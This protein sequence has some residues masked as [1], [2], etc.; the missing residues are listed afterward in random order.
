M[1]KEL[2]LLIAQ[3]N[4]IETINVDEFNCYKGIIDSHEIIISKCGIGKVNSALRTL[5]L[6]REFNPDLIINSGVAGSMDE[7]LPIG[8]V[9]LADRVAYHDVWCGPGTIIGQ[10]DGCP[11]YFKPYERGI[12]ILGECIENGELE[13]KC[14]LLCSGDQFISTL[15]EVKKIKKNFPEAVGCDMESASIA[16]TCFKNNV[17]FMVIRVM[18]DMPGSGDNIDQYKTFWNEAPLRTFKT[19]KLIIQKL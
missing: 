5:S 4:D 7:C 11:L 6:I 1:Q 17:P 18:S 3:V 9:L 19:V 15:D 16:Q 14:G 2:D 8:T 10:A 13:L 12:K